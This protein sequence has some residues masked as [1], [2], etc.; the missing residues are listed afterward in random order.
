MT[1]FA[2]GLLCPLMVFL[3]STIGTTAKDF[4]GRRFPNA[5]SCPSWGPKPGIPYWGP[6]VRFRREQ[7]LVREGSLLVKL[8]NSD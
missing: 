8:R 5:R 6:H 2:L 4:L 3:F 1:K 7:T